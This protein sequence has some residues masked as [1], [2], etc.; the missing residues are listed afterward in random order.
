MR[1]K[2]GSKSAHLVLDL[3][4][5]GKADGSIRVRFRFRLAWLGRYVSIEIHCKILLN[6]KGSID[7]VFR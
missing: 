3:I 1:K 2:R 7:K 4:C 5:N 6:K